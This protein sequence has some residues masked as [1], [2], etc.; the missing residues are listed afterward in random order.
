[1][2]VAAA[3]D[4]EDVVG[5]EVAVDDPARGEVLDPVR[6]LDEER[7]RLRP[8]PARVGRQRHAVEVLHREPGRAVLLADLVERDDVHVEE[9]LEDRGLAV[10]AHAR[11]G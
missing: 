2:Q 5:R 1:M 6:G 4:D 10:E 7:K 3:L 11:L 9:A 8:R